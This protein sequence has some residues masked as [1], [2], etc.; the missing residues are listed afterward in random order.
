MNFIKKLSNAIFGEKHSDVEI[1]E[2]Y[3]GYIITDRV[4]EDG[5]FT[6]IAKDESGNVLIESDDIDVI[7]DEIDKVNGR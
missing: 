7:L 4:F 6:Y 3:D 2:E 1:N 5:S